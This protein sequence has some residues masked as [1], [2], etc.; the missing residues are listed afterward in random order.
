MSE[1]DFEGDEGEFEDIPEDTGAL[2]TVE[3][4]YIDP[5]S[6]LEE[7]EEQRREAALRYGQIVRDLRDREGE[8]NVELARAM[9]EIKAGALYLHITNDVTGEP[10]ASFTDYVME[11][12]SGGIRR[13]EYY[14][15]IWRWFAVQFGEDFMARMSVVKFHKIKELAGLVT[16][17]TAQSWID[18]ALDP[19]VN[20]AMFRAEVSKAKK[21]LK[22]EETVEPPLAPRGA[23]SDPLKTVSFKVDPDQKTRLDRALA[24]AQEKIGSDMKSDMLL[25]LADV[26][27]ERHV[28]AEQA[29][30]NG[31]Q[32]PLVN[33][34][35]SLEREH[36]VRLIVIDPKTNDIVHGQNVLLE[37][38]DADPG[39]E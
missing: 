18:L 30:A 15:Q 22:E 9:Y 26:Y 21:A 31:D 5:S 3:E 35:Y 27:Y 28:A 24:I 29:A 4:G 1:Y 36:N 16:P 33:K 14:A 37:L 34:L 19:A 23:I 20:T 13:A 38:A 17:E 2:T 32:T 6:P 39:E 10:Y 7:V 25:E 11:E 8:L 12:V